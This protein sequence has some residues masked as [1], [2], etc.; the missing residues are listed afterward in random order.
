MLACC[1]S[2]DTCVVVTPLLMFE[3]SIV[4]H[5]LTNCSV[6][7]SKQHHLYQIVR[8]LW[9]LLCS[10][11]LCFFAC[12]PS[13]AALR[14]C[15]RAGF[16]QVS[17]WLQHCDITV[18]AP[19]LWDSGGFPAGCCQEVTEMKEGGG[20]RERD[21]EKRELKPLL[22]DLKLFVYFNYFWLSQLTCLCVQ[23]DWGSV[24]QRLRER[25]EFFF[26]I[27]STH[28]FFVVFD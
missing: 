3:T 14:S 19:P 26:S 23:D 9:L 17:F 16:T 15:V 18:S 12:V 6:S 21:R 28:C 13:A 20:E 1:E 7:A 27:F 10:C 5:T 22:L 8:L 24:H 11:W 4:S 25:R 2:F